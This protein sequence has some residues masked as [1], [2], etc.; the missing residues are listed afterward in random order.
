[1][2]APSTWAR[3]VGFSLPVEIALAS[4]RHGHEGTHDRGLPRTFRGHETVYGIRTDFDQL[5]GLCIAVQ[6]VLPVLPALASLAAALS[7]GRRGLGLNVG[8]LSALRFRA[9]VLVA[10]PFEPA[11][12]LSS[13]GRSRNAAKI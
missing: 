12:V 13:V 5:P 2:H 9:V 10:K 4:E 8:L 3:S 1:M 7:S 11:S 6:I